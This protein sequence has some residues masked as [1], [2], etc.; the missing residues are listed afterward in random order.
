[1]KPIKVSIHPDAARG[2]GHAVIHFEPCPV[3]TDPQV[4]F[5]IERNQDGQFLGSNAAWV[6]TMELLAPSNSQI[7][8][9]TL[10][11]EIGPSIVDPLLANS[12]MQ[13]RLIAKIDG[14]PFQ[15]VVRV[16]AGVY[17][18]A[19]RTSS[20][21]TEPVTPIA[22]AAIDTPVDPAAP[23][24]SVPP[25]G[26][27]ATP[28][29]QKKFPLIPVL[30]G[31]MLLALLGIGIWWFL[32]NQTSTV[33][34]TTTTQTQASAPEPST[35]PDPTAQ[36]ND[37][38]VTQPTAT[39]APVAVAPCSVDAFDQFEND[40][41]YLQNCV[42]SKPTTEQIFAVI[43][44]GKKTNRCDLIQRLYAHEAQAGNAEVALAYAKEFD[45]ESP[46]GECFTAPEPDAAIYWYEV[47][48]QQKPDDQI[49]TERVKA[50][51]EQ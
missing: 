16:T 18:S 40:F 27:P 30:A 5:S 48:L 15:G 23:D 42:D 46:R 44:S 41:D 8:G 1:M 2:P 39:P 14:S 29:H 6:P 43:E 11:C 12:Q 20:Q 33:G 32:S 10:K 24:V 22:A 35:E 25:A 26:T 31:I 17:P 34:V 37:P 21:P 19:A 36:S 47:Y 4:Q 38:A 13:Y 45:P 7:D 3:Q 51:K 28:S 50:L 49:V 9:S